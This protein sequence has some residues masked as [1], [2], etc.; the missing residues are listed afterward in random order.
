MADN[1]THGLGQVPGR[2]WSV[3]GTI[4]SILIFGLVVAAFFSPD[5]SCDRWTLLRYVLPVFTGIAAGSFAG[6]I[7]AQGSVNQLA[8][9]ATGGFA[10]WFISL[11]VVG[12]PDRCRVVNITHF[13]DFDNAEAEGP[14]GKKLPKCG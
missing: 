4:F 10:V 8:V 11:L 14:P 3:F 13:R 2:Y 5:S 9:A 1:G 12:V 6:A 7:S